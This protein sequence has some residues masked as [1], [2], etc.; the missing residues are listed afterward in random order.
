SFSESLRILT[1]L[2]ARDWVTRS[3]NFQPGRALRPG[4]RE[5]CRT[6]FLP[7]TTPQSP[8]SPTSLKSE[9]GTPSESEWNKVTRGQEQLRSIRRRPR[10]QSPPTRTGSEFRGW[11]PPKPCGYRFREFVSSPSPA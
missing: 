1:V 3:A 5:R 11:S 4:L 9:L 7:A 2:V 8:R 6:K 10:S